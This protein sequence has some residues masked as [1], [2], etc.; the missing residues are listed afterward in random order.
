[1]LEA[2]DIVVAIFEKTVDTD[3]ATAGE[4]AAYMRQI[5]AMKHAYSS[6]S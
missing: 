2:F 1:M 3:F 6:I 4:T 5:A